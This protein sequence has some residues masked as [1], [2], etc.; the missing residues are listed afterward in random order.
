MTPKEH[1]E[2]G[3]LLKKLRSLDFD[4]EWINASADGAKKVTICASLGGISGP[5]E[6]ELSS[7]SILTED[8]NGLMSRA[9]AS[10]AFEDVLKRRERLAE[11]LRA[12]GVET[13][14]PAENRWL[15][16]A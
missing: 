7:W 9:I 15:T 3:D 8:K 4:L 13:P 1:E 5:R 2:A 14:A 16:P 10:L 6:I 12:I 11:K